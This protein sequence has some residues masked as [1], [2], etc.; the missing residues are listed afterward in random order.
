M[1]NEPLIYENSAIV[2]SPA[3]AAETVVCRLGHVSN[4][5]ASAPVNLS[6]WINVTPAADATA[7]VLRVRRAVVAGHLVGTADTQGLGASAGGGATLV[8]FESAASADVITAVTC[9]GAAHAFSCLIAAPPT[10]M[11]NAGNIIEP[12]LYNAQL[13]VSPDTPATVPGTSFL[14]G[15][16]FNAQFE[17]AVDTL[18]SLGGVLLPDVQSLGAA[19]LPYPTL[20]DLK[21][22]AD[23]TAVIGGRISIQRLAVVTGASGAAITP[24]DSVL[25][26]VDRPG[27][28]AGAAY[29]L[30]AQMT[31]ASAPSV[32]NGVSLT[33]TTS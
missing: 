9:D 13:L 33:A 11:D 7:I 17:S 21:G 18:T 31:G 25:D 20:A 3:A 23:A 4:R 10:W 19:D 1:P 12:G 26:V 2:A 30:T 27:N 14:T 16:V 5:N 22:E 32:V 8:A 29:V 28:I 6:G 15:G 24:A